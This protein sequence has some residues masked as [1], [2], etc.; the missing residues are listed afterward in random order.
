MQFVAILSLTY[1]DYILSNPSDL[2]DC[3]RYLR[4]HVSI[5][6]FYRYQSCVLQVETLVTLHHVQLSS[7][8]FY[9]ILHLYIT[10]VITFAYILTVLLFMTLREVMQ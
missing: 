5:T 4:I 2:V 6:Y 10:E 8:A 7:E 3:M 1:L 9:Q